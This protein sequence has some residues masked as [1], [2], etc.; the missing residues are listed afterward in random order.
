MTTP[1]LPRQACPGLHTDTETEDSVQAL[2]R[3]LAATDSAAQG[4]QVEL[5]GMRLAAALHIDTLEVMKVRREP[6]ARETADSIDSAVETLAAQRV[7][8]GAIPCIRRPRFVTSIR[9][10]T[11][12][13]A[14]VE[15]AHEM[16]ADLTLVAAHGEGLMADLR[17]RRD[18]SELLRRTRCPVVLVNASASF[19]YRRI[20]IPTDFSEGSMAAARVALMLAPAAQITFLH[21]F[22]LD[23]EDLMRELGVTAD[24]I[25]SE[26]LRCARSARQALDTFMAGVGVGSR[27]ATCVVERG[28]PVRVI[29]RYAEQLG[30]DLIAIGRGNRSRLHELF[31]G[32]VAQ[33]LVDQSTS[34]LLVASQVAGD[35]WDDRPAA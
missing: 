31:L 25:A 13:K 20:L 28:Q 12:H 23:D 7:A 1:R 15:R 34:D 35:D 22:Q 21:V 32:S 2:R 9:Y 24:V 26:R 29:Q 5:R 17:T 30:A 6:A 10:G 19:P 16:N 4:G 33:R 11:P 3:I 18:N 8:F 27:I 14:I